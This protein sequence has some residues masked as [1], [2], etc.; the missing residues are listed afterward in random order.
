M[1]KSEMHILRIKNVDN[2]VNMFYSLDGENWTQ[3][4]NSLEVSGFHH[5]VLGGFL[6]LRIGLCAI[7]DGKVKFK[8]FAYIPIL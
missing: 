4:E 7:G 5:N 3:T 6:S 2:V 1:R 8:N